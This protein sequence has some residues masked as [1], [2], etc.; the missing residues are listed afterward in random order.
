MS[1]TSIL[2]TDISN[3]KLNNKL[4]NI[5][6]LLKENVFKHIC[7]ITKMYSD[8]SVAYIPW[9]NQDASVEIKNKV[10]DFHFSAPCRNNNYA[11]L[12]FIINNKYINVKA[13]RIKT[14]E[15]ISMDGNIL[16][17]EKD[18]INDSNFIVFYSINPLES[19]KILIMTTNVYNFLVSNNSDE[20]IR[21]FNVKYVEKLKKAFNFTDSQLNFINYSENFSLEECYEKNISIKRSFCI[22]T[23]YKMKYAKKNS[24]KLNY[25]VRTHFG[26]QYSAFNLISGEIRQFRDAI[27]RNNFFSSI[28]V[29]L[30]DNHN[31]IKNCKSMSKIV[32]GEDVD[33]YRTNILEN[34]WVICEYIADHVKLVKFVET[35][36]LILNSKSKKLAD[37]IK[38][39][40]SKSKKKIIVL[41]NKIIKS[42]QKLKFNLKDK[43]VYYRPFQQLEYITKCNT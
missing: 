20:H 23:L 42:V 29:K 7:N 11:D 15:A 6:F 14:F 1:D 25:N 9:F 24:K 43:L 33:S 22:K 10:Q 36:I 17:Y 38:K 27:A 41:T 34:G 18:T 37:R 32:N 30:S 13:C 3:L 19:D 21:F 4:Y 28:G 31:I 39:I 16:T 26:K 12:S 2:K 35:L 40:L 5:E 8:T